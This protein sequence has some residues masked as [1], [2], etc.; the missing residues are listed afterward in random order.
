MK[1][2]MITRS[3]FAAIAFLTALAVAA[4]DDAWA[5]KRGGG[6]RSGARSGAHHHHHHSRAVYSSAFFFGSPWWYGPHYYPYPPAI[7]YV[8]P[9]APIYVEQ[10][11]GEPTPGTTEVIYCP[12]RG[13]YYPDATDCPG[14]WARVVQ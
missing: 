5:G 6:A 3:A 11:V 13:A 2:R 7:A 9:A 12:N 8:E 4:P 14:G 1:A 10:Y